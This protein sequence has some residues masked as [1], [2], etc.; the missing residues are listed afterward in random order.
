MSEARYKEKLKEK[1][2]P[3]VSLTALCQSG[4][5]KLGIYP[6]PLEMLPIAK[7]QRPRYAAC[8]ALQLPRCAPRRSLRQPSNHRCELCA[9]Q[10][11]GVECAAVDAHAAGHGGGVPVSAPHKRLRET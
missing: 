8:T 7:K 5:S 10:E 3:R 6:K 4:L 11:R 1:K 2:R 9:P